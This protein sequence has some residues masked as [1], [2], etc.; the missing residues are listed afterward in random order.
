MGVEGWLYLCH[1][2]FTAGCSLV[3]RKL[4]LDHGMLVEV[5]I[6]RHVDRPYARA[7]SYI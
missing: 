4:K 3:S 5:Y 1:G 7:T 2:V 6:L